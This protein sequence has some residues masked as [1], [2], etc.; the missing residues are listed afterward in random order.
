MLILE[1][2]IVNEIV[3]ISLIIML[4]EISREIIDDQ[5]SHSAT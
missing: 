3:K 4:A 2:E 1:K 5:N